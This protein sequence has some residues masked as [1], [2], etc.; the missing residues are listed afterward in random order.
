MISTALLSVVLQA[1]P[2]GGAPPPRIAFDD[3]VA[4][5]REASARWRKLLGLAA[6]PGPAP[7]ARLVREEDAGDHARRWLEIELEDGDW[8]PACLLLPRGADPKARVPGILALHATSDFGVEETVGARPRDPHRAIGTDLVR[9]GYA[10]LAPR[11]FIWGYRGKMWKEACAELERVRPGT[12]GMAK[13]TSDAIRAMDFL[14][15]LPQVDADRLGAAGFS[16]GGKEVLYAAAFD[17]RVRA[18]VS[19]EGG[20]AV[21]FSNWDAPWYLGEKAKALPP[22]VDHHEIVA[23]ACPRAFLL[24]GGG[25]A[26]GDRSRPFIDAARPVYE[27]F[28]VPERLAIAIHREGH[29]IPPEAIEAMVTWFERHL[30]HPVARTEP[31]FLHPDEEDALIARW[32]KAHPDLVEVDSIE[33]FAGR[34]VWLIAL[35]SGSARRERPAIL[36]AVP[37]AHEPAG[38]AACFDTI[39]GVLEGE[40]LYG[41]PFPLD[42]RRVLETVTLVFIPDANPAGRARAPVRAWDGTYRENR[43]FLDIAFGTDAGTLARSPRQASWKLSEREPATIGIV[44]EPVSADELVEPNRDPRSSYFRLAALARSTYDVARWLDLHQTEFERSNTSAQV[45]LPIL[46]AELPDPIREENE[47]WA[48][49]IHEAWQAADLGEIR[50]PVALGYKGAQRDLLVASMGAIQRAMPQITTEIRNNHP[51]TPPARQRA[52]QAVAI[53]Q[54]IRRQMEAVGDGAAARPAS[55]AP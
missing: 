25:S 13:M 36:F 53:V 31:A 46:Q 17:P 30:R 14:A 10:V 7:R 37:H 28:R 43:G 44:Y 49:A 21:S 39:A 55:A 45:L 27:A 5:Q 8:T 38:S 11:N 20:V 15:S 50:P 40:G 32:A 19:M 4:W 22:G 24:V 1:S 47:A 29:D 51:G 54:T 33:S 12:T 9:A 2:G 18:A 34:K 26:D 3:P 42:R 16:L 41:R 48:R 52:L 23:L 6:E 35:G